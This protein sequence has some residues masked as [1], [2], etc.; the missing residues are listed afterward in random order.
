LE[1]QIDCGDPLPA[2]IGEPARC[3]PKFVPERFHQR[4]L[5]R[6]LNVVTLRPISSLSEAAFLA[7]KDRAWGMDLTAATRVNP[8]LA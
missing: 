6:F 7:F 5:P 3:R 2:C 4:Y 8:R 1:V